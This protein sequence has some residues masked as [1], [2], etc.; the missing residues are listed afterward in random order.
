[1]VK[2]SLSLKNFLIQ[3]LQNLH[4]VVGFFLLLLN[5]FAYLAPILAHLGFTGLSSAIYTIFGFLCHQRPW[6]SIHLFDYQA[7]W[8]T[9]DTFIYLSMTISSIVVHIKKIRKFHWQIALFSIIPIGIDGGV[10]AVAEI[11]GVLH[12]QVQ[13]FYVS[14]NFLR[15]L[16]G[17][18]F[19]AGIGLWLFS[20]LFDALFEEKF[21]LAEKTQQKTSFAKN[22]KIL[23]LIV[24]VNI[25]SYVLICLLWNFTS[26]K[27]KPY[28]I[29]DNKKYYPGI[30]YE[31]T[32]RRG[33]GV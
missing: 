1:M 29:L 2:K 19:G 18:I 31:Q 16:T 28:K 26:E 10:Q 14:T 9:R 15:M 11:L 21:I 27:Y 24:L 3:I 30:N 5:F 25:I 33:H 7:A 13:F 17:S 4:L 6:R 22:L 23:F 32:D 12:N 20:M 8:C